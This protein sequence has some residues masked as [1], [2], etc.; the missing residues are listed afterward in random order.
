MKSLKAAD[1]QVGSPVSYA[2]SSVPN[3]DQQTGYP[4]HLVSW[5]S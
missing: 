4:D 3:L 1:E 2:G 5:F